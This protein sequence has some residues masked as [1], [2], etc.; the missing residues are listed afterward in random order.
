MM[1]RQ[2]GR[3]NTK[4]G[5]Y[6]YNEA[7][8]RRRMGSCKWLPKTGDLVVCCDH[9]GDCF[10]DYIA[11]RKQPNGMY[12]VVGEF[13]AYTFGEME[14]KLDKREYHLLMAGEEVA[15]TF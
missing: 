12:K 15:L 2:W 11:I 1:N 3:G 8:H 6:I 10:N 13:G 9:A 4:M 14:K 7:E 5:V